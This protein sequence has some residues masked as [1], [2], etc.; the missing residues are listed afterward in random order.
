MSTI[1]N[2]ATVNG[3]IMQILAVII[4]SLLAYSIIHWIVRN[5]PQIAEPTDR[6]DY[7]NDVL[8]EVLDEFKR[9]SVKHPSCKSAH[10]A[11]AVLQEE[12]HEL[13]LEVYASKHNASKMRVEAIQ[14]ASSALRF[15]VDVLDS[16]PESDAIPLVSDTEGEFN[17]LRAVGAYIDVLQVGAHVPRGVTTDDL[18]ASPQNDLLV[19]GIDIASLINFRT[20]SLT[21]MQITGVVSGTDG[22]V[23]VFQNDATSTATLVLEHE[24]TNSNPVNRIRNRGGMS[25][26]IAPGEA[27]LYY[28]NPDHSRWVQIS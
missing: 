20:T 28:Y 24:S 3:L 5:R 27:R 25:T 21:P 19:N 26:L 12:V 1:D 14:V 22:Q 10:E 6:D 17:Q 4:F 9:A 2:A 23:V 7:A 15:V 8:D 11:L 18:T 13:M 16:K